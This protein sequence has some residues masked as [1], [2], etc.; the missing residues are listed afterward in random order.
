MTV[1]PERSIT[2]APAGIEGAVPSATGPSRR[3]REMTRGF[4]IESSELKPILALTAAGT[5]C[6]LS[7]LDHLTRHA[8]RSLRSPLA[9]RRGRD[10]G[11]LQS[12]RHAARAHGRDQG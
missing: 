4:R 7:C 3:K 6:T 2:F 11:G 12:E 1:Y 5:R 9:A 10:G 8:S